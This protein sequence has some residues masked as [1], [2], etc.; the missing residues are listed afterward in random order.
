MIIPVTHKK[1]VSFR[2]W[3]DIG[4][5]MIIWRGM[6]REPLAIYAKLLPEVMLFALGMF[7]QFDEK[8]GAVLP[9]LFRYTQDDAQTLCQIFSQYTGTDVQLSGVVPIDS[10]GL[11]TINTI[12]QI[13]SILYGLAL[14][15]GTMD[16][17]DDKLY[18]IKIHIPLFGQYLVYSQ[19]FD[20]WIDA[21]ATEYGIYVDVSQQKS[22]YGISYQMSISDEELLE[23]M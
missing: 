5:K 21:L 2:H 19:H 13:T 14:T 20:V 15:Y 4:S 9:F 8:T 17:R 22:S 3:K 18:G 1:K 23:C 7:S 12:H 6:M 10:Q 16:I 11:A